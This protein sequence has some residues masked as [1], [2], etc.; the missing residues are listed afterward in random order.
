MPTQYSQQSPSPPKPMVLS[1][2]DRQDSFLFYQGPNYP[3]RH[4]WRARIDNRKFKDRFG[5][6]PRMLDA[7]A[8]LAETS[9]PVGGVC[10]F[11]LPGALPVLLR[12]FAEDI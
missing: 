8:V 2:T 9:H 7:Q 10:P 3:D 11:G 6:K 1:L 4:T 5:T 12:H